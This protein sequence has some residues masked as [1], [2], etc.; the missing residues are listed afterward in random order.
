MRE[1]TEKFLNLFFDKGE[2]ICFS[3]NQYAYP[4]EP[5]ENINEDKTV[6]VAINPIKGQ[7][8]D[9]NVTTYR[10]F[11]VECD[12]M[13]EKDQ[14]KYIKE[15]G[16]PFSY[17]CYSGGKSLHFA[18]VLSHPIPG[19]D[20]YRHTYEWILNILS[21]A[22]QKTKNPSRSI[23]FPNVIRPDTGK[24]QT[25]LFIGERIS[26]EVL[27]EW[28]NKHPLQRPKIL[29]PRVRNDFVE[30]DLKYIKTWAVKTLET[31][32]HNLEGSRNQMWMSIGCEYS[33]AGFDLDDTIYYLEPYFE[34]Q[35]DFKRKEWET[36]V[37]SGWNYAEKLSK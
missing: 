16:F 7:R 20:I 27:S 33:L 4:S 34:E 5:Q 36:A 31:G 28:L 18:L 17:C 23:R 29:E 21:K 3:P 37:K 13:P 11:M 32:V 6:L 8:C 22:D 19:E 12:D 25:P 15:S 24:K 9:S 35:R 14:L 10:T 26:I 2:E 1:S 30:P